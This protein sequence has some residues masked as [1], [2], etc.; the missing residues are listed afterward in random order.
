M[1]RSD[2]TN[3]ANDASKKVAQAC[4]PVVQIGSSISSRFWLPPQPVTQAT[5]WELITFASSKPSAW[6]SHVAAWSDAAD[7]LYIHGGEVGSGAVAL[8][9]SEEVWF[10]SRQ[11]GFGWRKREHGV[12]V[13]F[14]L[15]LAKTMG[16]N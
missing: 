11:A 14:F 15:G 6:H 2:L 4:E 12:V 9:W 16:I 13:R 1:Q 3:V 7:G 10:F 5:T 8:D